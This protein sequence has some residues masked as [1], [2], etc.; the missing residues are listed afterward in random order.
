MWRRA[1]EAV[2]G[3]VIAILLAAFTVLILA[4]LVLRQASGGVR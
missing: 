1:G 3:V 2:Q 4:A